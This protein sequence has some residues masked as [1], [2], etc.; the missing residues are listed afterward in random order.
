[1]DE[2]PGLSPEKER[3]LRERYQSERD[4]LRA[5]LAEY[6]EHE[7]QTHESM[8]AILGNRTSFQ[9]AAKQL[10]AEVEVLRRVAEHPVCA[11]CLR[12]WA[13]SEARKDKEGEG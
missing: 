10:K 12:E 5:E 4:A 13:V 7:R 9:D 1:M 3:E 8:E 6:Q 2:R 11:R